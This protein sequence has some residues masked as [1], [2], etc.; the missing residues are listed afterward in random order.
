[1]ASRL[2]KPDADLKHIWR[3][4]LPDTPMPACGTGDDAPNQLY[5]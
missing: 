5:Q 1:M 2:C 4:L 3:M